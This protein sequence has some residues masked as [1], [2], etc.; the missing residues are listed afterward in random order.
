MEYM[1]YWQKLKDTYNSCSL[2]S[3]RMSEEQEGEVT[4]EIIEESSHKKGMSLLDWKDPPS[5]QNNRW[6]KE[7][8]G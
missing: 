7:P 4:K 2:I 5:V 8:S 6:I 3:R 1:F